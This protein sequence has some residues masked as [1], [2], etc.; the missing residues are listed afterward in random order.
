MWVTKGRRREHNGKVFILN[1]EMILEEMVSN[2][3]LKTK[4]KRALSIVYAG[5]GRR[6]FT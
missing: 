3:K 1:W 2:M 4:Y 5:A 6:G